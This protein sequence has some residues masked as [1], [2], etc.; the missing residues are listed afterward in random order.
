[1]KE[2][3]EITKAFWFFYLPAW[4]FFP[5]L[6]L[7]FR[8]FNA[9][10]EALTI[11]VLLFSLVAGIAP[12]IPWFRGKV[13]YWKNVVPAIVVPLATFALSIALIPIRSA[14]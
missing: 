6:V 10:S 1:M 5:A 11:P 12:W 2:I 14:A 4:I 13:S 7:L 9:P 3:V 8:G